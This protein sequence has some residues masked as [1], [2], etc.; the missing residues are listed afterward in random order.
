MDKALK[1]R[2][3]KKRGKK[4]TKRRESSEEGDTRG[5]NNLHTI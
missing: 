3:S 5:T 4:V 1:K 2:Q